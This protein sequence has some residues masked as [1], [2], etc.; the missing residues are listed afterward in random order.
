M[1]LVADAEM[2]RFWDARARED[3]GFFVDTRQPYRAAGPREFHD[4]EP[5]V[6]L[7]LGRLGIG[8]APGDA[9]LDLGCGVGRITRVL[10][11]RVG[12]VIALDVSPEMLA[13]ARLQNADLDNAEWMQG[14]GVSLAGI[15]DASL[16]AC[17][18]LVVFQH[19]PD[20]SIALGYVRELGR[21]LR[22]GGWVALEVSNDPSVHCRRCAPLARL[23]ALAGRGPRG[24][25]HSAWRG[26]ALDLDRLR[27]V[28]TDAGLDMV[29]TIGAGTQYCH[30]LLRR[31]PAEPARP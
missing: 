7:V 19:F 5:I 3:A 28:A 9:V 17:V 4:A 21:T 24:Q 31:P 2:R 30:V 14:D 26:S 11:G 13:R 15:A 1:N 16:D 6:D 29:R 8:L 20:P 12:A 22:P 23:R 18:S 25:G 27:A 10:A